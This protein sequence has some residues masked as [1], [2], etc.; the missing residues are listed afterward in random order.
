MLEQS[1]WPILPHIFQ[2]IGPSTL[3][4]LNYPSSILRFGSQKGRP[5]QQ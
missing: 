4:P 1:L 2:T 5:F 3:I